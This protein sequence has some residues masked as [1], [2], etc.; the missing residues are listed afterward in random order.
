[1]YPVRGCSA[2]DWK[3]ILLFDDKKLIW[4]ISDSIKNDGKGEK[5]QMSIPHLWLTLQVTVSP[6]NAEKFAMQQNSPN[7]RRS[8]ATSRLTFAATLKSSTNAF[9]FESEEDIDASSLNCFKRAN[10]QRDFF[11]HKSYRLHEVI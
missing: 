1:M 8:I 11:K 6:W 3:A 4:F 9:L 10:R 2:F 7:S 5:S